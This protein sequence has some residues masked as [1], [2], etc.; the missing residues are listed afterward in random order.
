MGR[1]YSEKLL[2]DRHALRFQMQAY[3]A[4]S[5]PAVQGPRARRLRRPRARGR[6]PGGRQPPEETWDFFANGMLINVIAAFDLREF[7][8]QDDWAT[9]WA[10]LEADVIFRRRRR[11]LWLYAVGFVLAAVFALPVFG[12]LDSAND[13][14]DPSAEAV[15]ARTAIQDATGVT[16]APDLIV[17]VRLGAPARPGA[18]PDRAAR[19]ARPASPRSRATGRAATARSKDGRSTYLLASSEHA[20]A[21]T[22]T[23][24]ST[25]SARLPGR[26]ARRRRVRRRRSATRSPRTSRAPS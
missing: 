1:A 8:G 3:A 20:A 4:A 10:S 5:D 18:Q 19:A 23:R 12:E 9:A 16:A 17:L 26:H 21:A 6:R 11:I 13:F 22:S 24:S 7:A 15:H 2:P 25:G 14:D